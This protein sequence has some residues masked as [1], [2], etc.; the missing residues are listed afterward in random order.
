MCKAVCVA[1]GSAGG[2]RVVACFCVSSF[3]VCVRNDAICVRPCLGVLSPANYST[4]QLSPNEFSPLQAMLFPSFLLAAFS[5]WRTLP[6][7][8][9]SSYS[10]FKAQRLLWVCPFVS[11]RLPQMN[12]LFPLWPQHYVNSLTHA[13]LTFIRSVVQCL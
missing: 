10:P 5:V 1:G 9:E 2:N 7:C 3:G 11:N 13:M 4:L 6:R 8:L 12:H